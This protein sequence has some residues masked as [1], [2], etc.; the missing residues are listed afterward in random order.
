MKNL[1]DT[2]FTNANDPASFNFYGQL[3]S[4]TS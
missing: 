3:F 1:I 4:L 2:L